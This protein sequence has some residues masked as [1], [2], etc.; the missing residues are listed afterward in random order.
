MPKTF[1]V[2]IVIFGM[3]A[4]CW[5]QKYFA[6]EVKHKPQFPT[7]EA[8]RLY[9]F[10]CSA[11]QTE[12]RT[13]GAVRPKITLVLGTEKNEAQ[14]NAH[15]IRLTNW[16]PYLFTEGVEI[17]AFEDLMSVK[18]RVMTRRAINWADAS[19]DVSLISK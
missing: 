2:V 18:E 10:A 19:V 12:F 9:L 3:A 14:F 13:T 16:D 7:A 1:S 4:G 17:F 5:E 11:I 8:D 6:V 15:E